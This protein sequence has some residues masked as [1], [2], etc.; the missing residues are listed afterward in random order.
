MKQ[1]VYSAQ[2][3]GIAALPSGLM[4]LHGID[5]TSDPMQADI[6]V[7]PA[8]LRD[9]GP[10][11]FRNLPFL[12]SGKERR[13]VAW[14]VADDM[15][16]HYPCGPLYLRC[17]AVKSL[18]DRCPTVRGWPWPVD[19]LYAPFAGFDYDVVFQ[20]W[21]STDLTNIVCDSVAAYSQAKGEL[22]YRITKHRFFFG[23][24]YHDPA[25]AHWRESFIDTLRRS[26]LSLVPRSIPAGVIRYRFYEA[27]SAGR[28]PVH[29]CDGRVLPW[30]HKIDYSKCSLHIPESDAHGAG[31]IIAEWLRSHSD[32]QIREMG[33][34]GRAAWLRWLDPRKWDQR[35]SEAV[36]EWLK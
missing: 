6:F 23:Y 16:V 21:A 14:N 3:M 10:E 2:Q 22:N 20:G 34:Y 5:Q 27:L 32:K 13:H 17:E 15:T 4:R 36:Q 35:F 33:D 11:R 28:V 29:F 7:V 26:R 18:V 1:Y 25:Y 19:D 30:A 31:E 9:L 24:H 12:N 8:T